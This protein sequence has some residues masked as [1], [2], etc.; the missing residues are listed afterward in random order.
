MEKTKKNSIDRK[1]KKPLQIIDSQGFMLR[2]VAA[3]GLEPATFG[4]CLPTTVFTA[5]ERFGI[6]GLDFLFIFLIQ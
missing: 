4:L 1:N 5:T 2:F 3:A 6:C